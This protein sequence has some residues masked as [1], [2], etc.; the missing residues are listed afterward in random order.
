MSFTFISISSAPPPR[1]LMIIC[2][3]SRFICSQWPRYLNL[4]FIL[5]NLSGKFVG[6]QRYNPEGLKGK[7][8]YK[9][10]NDAKK[11]FTYVTK[12]DPEKNISAI[13]L[14]G[15]H[16]LDKRLHVFI[17][18]GVFDAI[19]LI[20]VNQPVIAVLANDPKKI[21][22]FFFILQKKIIVIADNDKA[23][24]KLK[25]LSKTSYAVPE[26]FKDLGDMPLDEVNKF[27]NNI[28]KG[29]KYV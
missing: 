3:L 24:K 17:V 16:T 11:Y 1:L 10:P 2:F 28:L 5:F 29:L 22:N 9:L 25:N 8:S 21:K 20:R 26:S 4:N 19:K 27:V 12:E 7:D 13:G 18:E 14:Y 6:Y 23:G 15:L